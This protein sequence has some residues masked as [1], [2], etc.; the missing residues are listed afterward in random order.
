MLSSCMLSSG[1]CTQIAEEAGSVGTELRDG[2]CTAELHLETK[3]AA[4]SREHPAPSCRVST[5][6][7]S[8]ACTP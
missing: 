3:M 4:S 6:M 1:H 8:A 2:Q 7:E 5:E